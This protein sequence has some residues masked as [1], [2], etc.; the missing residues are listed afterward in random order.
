MPRLPFDFE[1]QADQWE[2]DE[3][4]SLS[5]LVAKSAVLKLFEGLGIYGDVVDLGCGE[6]FISRQLAAFAKKVVGVDISE[7]MIARAQT[8]QKLRR[9]AI[10]YV[11]GDITAMPFFKSACFDIGVSVFVTNYLPLSSL[12]GF[13]A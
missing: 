5:D 12:H 6:G 10:A 7:G 11:R 2:R 1:Y 3:P 4:I 8:V 9:Q 13:Y